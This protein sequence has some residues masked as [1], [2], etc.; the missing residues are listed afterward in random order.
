MQYLAFEKPLEALALEVEKIKEVAEKTKVDVSSTIEE[1]NK[2]IKTT[3]KRIYAIM[4]SVV[5]VKNEINDFIS[6]GNIAFHDEVLFGK[7]LT[8]VANQNIVKDKIQA[9]EFK[10]F[11]KVR[12]LIDNLPNGYM[13]SETAFKLLGCVGV[14][15]AAQK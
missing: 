1:L 6:K 2:K 15:I 3:K 10:S 12:K 11:K 4:P 8:K 5:N 14:K 7:A 13:S 9:L